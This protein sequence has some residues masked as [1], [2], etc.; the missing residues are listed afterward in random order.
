[1]STNT[2]NGF[3]SLIVSLLKIV[4]I[5]VLAIMAKRTSF[6]RPFYWFVVQIGAVMVGLFIALI[7]YALVAVFTNIDLHN[8]ILNWFCIGVMGLFTLASISEIHNTM[9]SIENAMYGNVVVLTSTQKVLGFIYG[10]LLH[11]WLI[12]ELF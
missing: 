12:N 5:G 2:S 11:L 3:G 8:T 10:L 4:I 6:T 1:M 9:E 7:P